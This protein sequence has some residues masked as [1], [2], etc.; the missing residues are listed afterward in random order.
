MGTQETISPI[1]GEPYITRV[2]A[3]RST[4]D[5]ALQAA[6]QAQPQW[7]TC[8]LAARS[9]LLSR[10]VDIL[11]ED[12]DSLAEELTWQVGRPI[13]QSAGE[14]RGF[15]ERA[16]AMIA[17]APEAMS[18]IE[19][20]PKEGFRRFISREPLGT[21]LALAA[22][23]YPYLIAVNSVFPA[24]LAGNT[25]ILKHSD[26]TP[27]VSER[28][29]E[30]LDKAGLPTGV[31]QHIHMSHALTAE[32]V[33]DPRVDY[34]A[35]TGSVA[36]G[37]AVHRAAAGHLK[38]VGLE[39]GGKDPAYVRHDADIAS[40]AGSL[41]DGAYF[42]SGQSCCG[43]E[44]IYV[45]EDV[46]SDFIDTFKTLVYQY[47]LGD[48]R[49]PA[50]TLGPVVRTRNADSIRAQIDDAL[51]RGAVR[52]I[53]EKYFPQAQADTPYLAPQ[54]LLN[55]DHSMTIMREETFGPVVGIMKVSSDAEA[56]HLMNDSEYGLTASI[57]TQDKN[58][59]YHIGKQLE[60]GTVFMNRCDYLDPALAWVGVK[61][62]GRG[63]T[64]SR[65]GFEQLTRPKSFHFNLS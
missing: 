1:T 28:I 63:C 19:V 35:F 29:G 48:P 55:V 30:A 31:Y 56:I 10:A 32:A 60:T 20:G 4:L 13:S 59:A 58:E 18:R 53:D 16:R 3:S 54:A 21:V 26:Q 47:K 15:E 12:I 9:H 44:R 61:K 65:V 6:K 50:T 22:W 25:V 37:E 36:G 17:L 57:W 24:L 39:L 45:H 2:L 7:R 52:L 8:G 41:V 40:A 27:L 51:Q 64:L 11:L 38:A 33:S 46:Y 43:V 14:L 62:S 34:V 23:N 49:D 42:N 5:E